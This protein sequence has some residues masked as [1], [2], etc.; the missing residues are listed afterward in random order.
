MLLL[1]APGYYAQTVTSASYSGTDLGSDK[2]LTTNSIS[3]CVANLTVNVPAGDVI[4]S[5]VT[6]Y[7]MWSISGPWEGI[8]SQRSILYCSTN[9]TWE[10]KYSKCDTCQ[11]HAGLYTYSRTSGIAN[12]HVSNGA[13]NFELH[14]GNMSLLSGCNTDHKLIGSSFN[15][16]VYSTPLTT[17]I[18]DMNT[19]EFVL[20]KTAKNSYKI[21]GLN[22]NT[23]YQIIDVTGKVLRSDT[24]SNGI[25][26]ESYK[27]GVYFVIVPEI[28]KS[29]KLIH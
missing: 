4:D 8:A 17:S 6:N 28:Q 3:T 26:F 24:Y 13:V 10:S 12:G 22:E 9:T 1:L 7:E 5:L 16:T 15:I 27:H 2:D 29:Y 18:E 11:F 23:P 19:T 14:L 20:S 21:N 25:S